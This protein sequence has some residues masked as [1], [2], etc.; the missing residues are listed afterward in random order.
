MDVSTKRNISGDM[1]RR[2]WAKYLWWEPIWGR[3]CW[4]IAESILPIQKG[5]NYILTL[6]SAVT[7]F[8]NLL[9]TNAG[10]NASDSIMNGAYYVYSGTGGGAS[11]GNIGNYQGGDG[12]YYL[13]NNSYTKIIGGD[14]N[15]S[16]K[17]GGNIRRSNFCKIYKCNLQKFY[18]N[19]SIQ[20]GFM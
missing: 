11:G 13:S 20:S 17:Y 15:S 5:S 12:K 9:S 16:S 18:R 8:G 10:S 14:T 6:D 3:W 19:Y 4:G 2:G 7:S 1:H